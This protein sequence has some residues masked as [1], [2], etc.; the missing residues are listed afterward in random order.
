MR[1]NPDR[2][3]DWFDVVLEIWEHFLKSA[4]LFKAYIHEYG[5]GGQEFTD[6]R[7]VPEIKTSEFLY[8]RIYTIIAG[9]YTNMIHTSD[10]PNVIKMC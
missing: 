3:T 10:R 5:G 6:F 9:S 8:L 7:I 4:N 2:S 1:K